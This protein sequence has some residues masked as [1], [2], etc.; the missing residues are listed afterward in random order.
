MYTVYP[1]IYASGCYNCYKNLAD[2]LADN[3]KIDEALINYEQAY[4]YECELYAQ[5]QEEYKED[6]CDLL[7]TMAYVYAKLDRKERSLEMIDKAIDLMP[8]EAN[9]YDTKGE[10]LLMQGKTE[11]ALEMWKKV[12]ELNPD[13][14]KNYPDGT[15]LSNGLNKLGWI[16]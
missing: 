10:I 9:F 4:K 12:L 5:T 16:K 6:L 13:F 11:E 3:N 15:N 14:L 7:N 2:L 8:T 1:H